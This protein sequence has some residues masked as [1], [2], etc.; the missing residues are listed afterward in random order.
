MV[1]RGYPTQKSIYVTKVQPHVSPF[2][3]SPRGL[4]YTMTIDLTKDLISEMPL[5][6][7]PSPREL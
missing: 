2:W 4:Y 5:E 7:L 3:P 1:M 6:I